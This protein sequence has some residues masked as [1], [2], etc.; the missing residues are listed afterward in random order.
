ME[1]LLAKPPTVEGEFLEGFKR[2]TIETLG[3][4]R[5]L[6]AFLQD[7]LVFKNLS[8]TKLTWAYHAGHGKMNQLG[9]GDLRHGK[10]LA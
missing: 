10:G 1:R 4:T 7:C 8:T 9:G 6:V 5:G 3:D 2:I